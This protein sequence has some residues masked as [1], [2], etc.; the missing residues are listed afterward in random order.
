M[1]HIVSV[2][3]AE[4]IEEVGVHLHVPDVIKALAEEEHVQLPMV[5]SH[6]KEIVQRLSLCPTQEIHDAYVVDDHVALGLDAC[7]VDGRRHH[8]VVLGVLCLISILISRHVRNYI[9]LSRANMSK[10]LLE[11]ETLC[12]AALAES[13]MLYPHFRRTGKSSPNHSFS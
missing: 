7:V 3:E 4:E 1:L 8:S 11:E 9:K 6:R 10:Q 13:C 5:A 2:R 12:H